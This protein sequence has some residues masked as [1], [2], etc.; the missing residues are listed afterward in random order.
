VTHF[1]YNNAPYPIRDD[2]P[3]AYRAF[4]QRLAG[5]G[6]W[7]SGEQRVAIAAEVRNATGCGFCARR[8][9]ALSPYALEGQHDGGASLSEVA[10]DA[11][12]R[13]VTDQTRI[14][15]S[16]VQ[17]NID[18]GLSEEHYV[19]LVGI[20]VAVFSIDEFNRGL[21]LPPE[22]LPQPLAGQP[23]HY[24][25]S[26]AVHGTG[27]VPMIPPDGATGNEADLWQNG[28]TANVLR[29][30][31]LVPNALRDW[32]ALGDVQYLSMEGMEKYSGDMGRA[33]DR[34]QIELVAG[35]VSAYNE[36]FY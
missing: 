4:W 19:E 8:K 28:M 16:F 18:R 14:T 9:K 3:E 11:V 27:F 13:V 7:W 35:R 30:L 23:D 2:L 6:N 26:Q 1:N 31:T 17:Q 33:I 24:R 32:F 5:P 25:P 12:H 10:I 21:G 15:R 29:A 20:V 36:C 34:M 22:P